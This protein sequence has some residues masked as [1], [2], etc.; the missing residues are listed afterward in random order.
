MVQIPTFQTISSK[1]LQEIIVANRTLELLVRW[2]SRA[3]A[4][5]MDIKDITEQ[6]IQPEILGIKIVPNWALIRQYRSYL[7]DLKGDIIAIK[8]DIEASDDITYNNLNNGWGLFFAD[9]DEV[10]SWEDYYGLG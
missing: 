10:E 7:P 5:Y 6:E 1:F 2:I 3:D 9:F 8:T 4:W